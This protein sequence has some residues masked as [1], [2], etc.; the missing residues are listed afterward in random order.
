MLQMANLLYK[1]IQTVFHRIMACFKAT[2]VFESIFSAQTAV[3]WLHVRKHGKPQ[4]L[5]NAIGVSPLSASGRSQSPEV[6]HLNAQPW[7]I[8]EE[9]LL[10]I[11]DVF[12]FD[13]P[14]A[15]KHIFEQR[16]AAD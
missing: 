11:D 9:S 13:R 14:A 4:A 10:G 3:W 15:N 1:H 6:E 5:E 2:S 16:P 8:A 7:S 12:V